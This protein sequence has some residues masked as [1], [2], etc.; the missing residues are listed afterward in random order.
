MPLIRIPIDDIAKLKIIKGTTKRKNP[1][2]QPFPSSSKPS[3]KLI[4]MLSAINV[5][6]IEIT[7]RPLEAIVLREWLFVGTCGGTS[8]ERI[9][10]L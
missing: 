4:V 9:P 7:P 6:I 5:E 10:K 3:L 1:K 2:G 8:F